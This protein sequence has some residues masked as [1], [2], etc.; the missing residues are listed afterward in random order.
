MGE[1]ME[2]TNEE[3]TE[4]NKNTIYEQIKMHFPSITLQGMMGSEQL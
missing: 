2:E 1:T 4:N 3:G